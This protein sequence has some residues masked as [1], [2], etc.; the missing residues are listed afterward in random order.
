MSEQ[1]S[2]EDGASGAGLTTRWV[3][4]VFALLL[5][6]GAAVVIYDSVRIGAQWGSDG[7]QSGYFPWLVGMSI[8]LSG[9]W[10]VAGTLWRWKRMEGVVFVTWARLVPVLS[11]LLPSMAFVAAIYFI[12]LYEAAALFIAGFMVWQGK[13]RWLATLSVALG[14]PIAL[15]LLFEVWFLVPLPKGPLEHLLGY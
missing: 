15:F 14:V 10:I 12:G 4:L 7:P 6:L 3:E 8:L 2:G 9:V 1:T 5:V 11:M 13:Y